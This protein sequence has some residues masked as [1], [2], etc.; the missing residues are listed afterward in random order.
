[1]YGIVHKGSATLH[2][3]GRPGRRRPSS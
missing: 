2:R 1:V 3:K